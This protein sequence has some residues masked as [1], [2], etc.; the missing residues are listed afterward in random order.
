MPISSSDR[1][2]EIMECFSTA[3]LITNGGLETRG[4]PMAVAVSRKDN[5]LYFLSDVT[6]DK[7][8]EIQFD[9]AVI[10]AFVDPAA[11]KYAWVSGRATVANDR[12]RIRQLWTPAAE[13]WWDSAE[14]PDIRVVKVVPERADYWTGGGKIASYAALASSEVGAEEGPPLAV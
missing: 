11:H 10:V 4:R 9:P 8:Y 7:D 6:S 12:L 1:A 13:A 2:W 14:D 3:L 5:A